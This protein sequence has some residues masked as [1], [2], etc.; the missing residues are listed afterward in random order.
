MKSYYGGLWNQLFSPA[1]PSNWHKH[2]RG[3]FTGCTVSI[4]LILAG[5]NVILEFIVAG[6]EAEN[7]KFYK[8]VVT[9]A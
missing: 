3:I 9:L 7:I 2:L 5:T 4:I 6:T 1:E 8:K